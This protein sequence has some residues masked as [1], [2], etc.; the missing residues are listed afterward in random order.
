M[1]LL[2][3]A[4]VQTSTATTLI[5]SF[6]VNHPSSNLRIDQGYKEVVDGYAYWTGAWAGLFGRKIA[7]ATDSYPVL[8]A[9]GGL[10]DYH[11]NRKTYVMNVSVGDQI[12]VGYRGNNAKVSYHTSG[13][14][15]L[16][17]IS[18]YDKLESDQYYTVTTAGNLC[19]L[20]GYTQ[21][22]AETFIDY[23]IIET[24]TDNVSVDLSNGLCTY[25]CKNP[26]DFSGLTSVKA[27]VATGY[28]EGKF[29][30][31]QVNYVP[32]NTGFLI[33]R[34]GGS[35]NTAS[36][37]FGRNLVYKDNVITGN[38]F[39]GCLKETDIPV[40]DDDEYKYYCLGKAYG[41]IGCY[42]MWWNFT[43]AANKAYIAVKK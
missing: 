15:A 17:G 21:G 9:N 43:C 30:F 3:M 22:S 24:S 10:V 4:I 25:C 16:S 23:I 27:F 2:M 34:D 42:L 37:P 11:S 40:N 33:V 20:T 32:S 35:V 28:N 29:T 18:L 8:H 36:I 41:Y 14:A 13:G 12:C 39:I 1:A 7:F 38:L 31:K 19:L 6:T 5:Y 26:L